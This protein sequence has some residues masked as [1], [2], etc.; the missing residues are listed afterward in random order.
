MTTERTALHMPIL[1]S[2]DELEAQLPLLRAR[3]A[4]PGDRMEAFAAIADPILDHASKLDRSHDHGGCWEMASH[5]IEL[6]LT[7][8][9]WID[10][11]GRAIA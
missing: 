2:L 1:Q 4:E 5:R 10:A 8:A 11:D 3:Y 6:M 9:G 7:S